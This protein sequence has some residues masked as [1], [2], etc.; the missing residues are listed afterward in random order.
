MHL[1]FLELLRGEPLEHG[2]DAGFDLGAFLIDFASASFLVLFMYFGRFALRAAQFR[3]FCPP[4][5][6]PI[7]RGFRLRTSLSDHDQL[8]G[9]RPTDVAVSLQ[10]LW[11][12]HILSLGDTS[13]GLGQI[14]PARLGVIVGLLAGL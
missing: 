13:F 12:R 14:E 2:S 10:E 6:N 9:A 11:P 1:K 5:P 3:L 4:P 7:G 8:I